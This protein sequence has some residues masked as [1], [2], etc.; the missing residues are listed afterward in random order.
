MSTRSVTWPWGASF[1]ANMTGNT[2]LLGLHVSLEQGA[3]ALRS[4]VALGGFGG[5]LLI[6]ALIVQ[7]GPGSAAWPRAVNWALAV[8]ER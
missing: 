2:V 3:A 6:G 8:G 5:G 7:R 4:L 1:T